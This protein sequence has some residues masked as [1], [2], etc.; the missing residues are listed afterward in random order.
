M[1]KKNNGRK[2]AKKRNMK[3]RA[4]RKKVSRAINGVKSKRDKRSRI[5]YTGKFTLTRR[6][7]GFVS[8]TEFDD[9]IFIPA[10]ATMG[11]LSGDEVRFIIK[12][13]T[14]HGRLDGEITEIIR[15]ND[16]PV[17]GKLL[18]GRHYVR[19]GG[20]S[21]RVDSFEFIPDEKSH[22]PFN[23]RISR[24]AA[25]E[26]ALYDRVA[27][28]ILEYPKRGSEA[29]GRVE[30]IFGKADTI[31]SAVEAILYSSG[32]MREFSP[33]VLAEA[34]AMSGFDG[35]ICERL[36]LRAE[37]VFTIDSATARDLDD[38]ISVK[39]LDDGYEL[40]VHIADVAHY[41]KANTSI[42]REARAR[43]NSV[44]FPSGVIPMLPKALS[45]GYCSLNRDS[46]K[47]TLS[48]IIK[49]D[50]KGEILSCKIAESVISSA[51]R[52][53]Y[54]E[55]NKVLD[56]TADADTKKKYPPEVIKMLKVAVKLYGIL[57]KRSD[58]RGCFELES[59]EAEIVLDE[60]GNPTDIVRVDRGLTE[61]LIE[62][63]ML[64][65]NEAV[66]RLVCAKGLLGVY[67]V[68]ESPDSDKASS[69]ISYAGSIG[70]DVKELKLSPDR[71]SPAD[72]QKLLAKGAEK[73][74]SR[75]LSPVLLRSLMK[76]RYDTKPLGHFG[77]ALDFYSHFTSPIRRYSDLILHRYLKEAIKNGVSLV[78]NKGDV[79][80]KT[81]TP[82]NADTLSACE[83]A[84]EGE[85]RAIF[86]ERDIVDVYKA[87][88][89]KN[90]IGNE[91]E[92]IIV[93]V[94]AFGFFVELDNTCE[95]LVHISSLSDDYYF[96]E[97]EMRLVGA[98]N[99]FSVGDRVKVTLT[100]I[101]L[102]TGK[103]GFELVSDE[104]CD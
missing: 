36:D 80:D 57:K 88:F 94:T 103:L 19:R 43:G 3:Q 81:A 45:N 77:L 97:D 101:D 100:D 9:D 31:E 13:Q 12:H 71:L 66:S 18:P 7:F 69:L 65:A 10:G 82:F 51:A 23:V 53:V 70:I 49:L 54:S 50:N 58:K 99:S 87:H 83:S 98:Y 90:Q 14:P 60:N 67:R 42:D 22:V 30:H 76:A 91:F 47:L 104:E 21:V 72:I 24:K 68:H 74:L 17:I 15:R 20:S 29:V 33:A 25:G 1:K 46:D 73:G 6:D 27:I 93:S 89:M 61:R 102:S 8:C 56:K 37:T 5:F 11:A 32:V 26:A 92:G 16:A 59:T 35:D 75:A 34:E 55:L 78:Y 41:V 28:K 95:G 44:Y 64:C 39:K 62:Q 86:A 40:G 52:G 96:L 48:A 84:N 63:F 4:D 2:F 85:V 38:A 79:C